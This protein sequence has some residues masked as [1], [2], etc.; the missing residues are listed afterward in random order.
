M[1]K[2]MLVPLDGSPLAERVLPYARQLARKLGFEIIFLHVCGHSES[3][4]QFMCQAYIKHVAELLRLQSET[5][6]KEEL[7]NGEPIK[8]R[9]EIG[10]GPIVESISR[11]VEENS[12]DLML[13]A[14]HG[15]SGIG[16]WTIG[17]IAHKVITTSK[18]PI[19]L[20]HPNTLQ[21]TVSYEWP[22][23]ILMPMD[24]S[25]MAEFV[26]SYVEKLLYQSGLKPNVVLLRVCEPPDL[27]ADYP[28][29]TMSLPW[30]EHIRKATDAS[31]KACSLY[32]SDVQKRLE[33]SGVSTH[34]EVI[35]GDNV[36]HEIIEYVRN[37][38]CDL[39]AM[40]THGRSG[41]SLWPYGHVTDRIVREISA[42]L[43]LVRPY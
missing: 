7:L 23:T 31:Q 39:I 25:P 34:T 16:G 41:I 27:L 5:K 20:I 8:A 36:A 1:Y 28:E 6:E 11:F 3:T 2:K 33:V 13:L 12:I 40:S 17:S 43:F 37:K 26:L 15:H 4:S 14:T 29:A 22:R 30:K 18:T 32:L 19:L 9:G 24:G 10:N 42:P 38:P 35:L 21:N